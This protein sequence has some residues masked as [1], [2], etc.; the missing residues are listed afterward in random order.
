MDMC[1][2]Y[3]IQRVEIE[4]DVA[5][6]VNM[7]SDPSKIHWQYVYKIRCVQALISHFESINLIFREQN[8]AADKLA[9]RAIVEAEKKEYFHLQEVTREVQRIIF[10]DRIGMPNFRSPSMY[11]YSFSLSAHKFF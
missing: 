9:R 2:T 5:L 6:V 11:G 10:L 4:M 1:L 8:M 7:I 3:G